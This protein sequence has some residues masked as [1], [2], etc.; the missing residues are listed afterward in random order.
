MQKLLLFTI[1][2]FPWASQIGSPEFRRFVVDSLPW[3]DLHDMRDIV[4][5][6]Q[7]TSEEIFAIKKEALAAGDEAV[8][9]QVGQG[10]DIMS[11]LSEFSIDGI[12]I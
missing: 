1:T 10:K 12:D 7:S 11:I 3:K 8:S 2:V 5:T 6:M 4:N 9:R